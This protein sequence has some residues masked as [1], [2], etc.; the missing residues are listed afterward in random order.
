MYLA[1]D[2]NGQLLLDENGNPYYKEL[3]DGEST[4]GK[5]MLHYAD[6]ITAEDT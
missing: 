2:E 1:Q 3:R 6:T 5:E 4:F